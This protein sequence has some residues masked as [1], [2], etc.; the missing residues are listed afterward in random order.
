ML[1]EEKH[2]FEINVLLFYIYLPHVSNPRVHL[3]V[4]C[5]TYTYVML[6]Y[7]TSRHVMLCYVKLRHVTL[8]YVTLCYFTLLR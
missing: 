8:C 3:H 1:T 7:V 4:D 2:N 5:C 6:R